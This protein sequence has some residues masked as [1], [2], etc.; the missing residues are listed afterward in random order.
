MQ[1]Y[2]EGYLADDARSGQNDRGCQRR[3]GSHSGKSGAEPSHRHLGESVQ[4]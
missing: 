4:P 2:P 3:V 1:R